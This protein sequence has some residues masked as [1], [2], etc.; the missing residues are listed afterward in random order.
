M[1]QSIPEEN[2]FPALPR[3]SRRGSPPTMVSYWTA[4]WEILVGKRRGKSTDP[5][6]HVTGSMTLLLPL[7][8]KAHVHAPFERRTYSAGETPEV[9]Q[10]PCKHW[11]GILRF[12]S[13]IHTRSLA[14]ALKGEESREALEQFACGL[15]FPEATRA[16]PCGPRRKLRTPAATREIPGGFALQAR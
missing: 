2:V 9:A 15:S 5:L 13:R 12:R 3:L 4:L 8:R 1:C 7:W 10:E 14:P 16:G 6:I 11:R